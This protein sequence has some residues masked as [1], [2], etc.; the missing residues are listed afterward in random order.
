[1]SYA[2]TQRHRLGPNFHLL[3]INRPGCPVHTHQRDG[4][5]NFMNPGPEKHFFTG[6]FRAA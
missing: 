3:P 6:E 5:M 4:L 1:M 2:D